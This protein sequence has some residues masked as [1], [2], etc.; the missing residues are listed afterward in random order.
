MAKNKKPGRPTPP[1]KLFDGL[2]SAFD[3]LEEHKP[4]EALA[5]LEDLD[6]A[7]PNSPDVLELLTNA[8]YDLNNSSRYEYAIRKLARIDPGEPSFIYGLAGAYLSNQ[9]P[10]LALRTFKEALRRWPN[11]EGA[12]KAREALPRIEEIMREQAAHLPSLNEKQ[13]LD[14]MVQHDELRCCLAHSEYYQ[15]RQ[16][17]EKLLKRYPDFVPA[18]NNL[19]QIHAVEGKVDLAIQT[20]LKVL[21][22]EPENIH[23][24]SNLTRLYFLSGRTAEASQYAA[25]L[26][27]S[28]AEAADRWTKIAEALTFLEDDAGVLALYDRAKAAGEQNPPHTDELFYHLLAVAAYFQGEEKDA[29]K[30]WK[31]SLEINPHFPWAVQ[32]LEDLKKPAKERGGAWAFPSEN[33]LLTPVIQE[34][35]SNVEKQARRAKKSDPQTYLV[36]YFEKKHPELLFLAPHLLA[37]GDAKGRDFAVRAA[38]MTALPDLVAA[39]KA[40]VFGK[41]GSFNE[42][43]QAAQILTEAGMIPSSS[44]QM[45]TGEKM[46]DVILMNIEISPEP[47]PSNMPR[48]AHDLATQAFEALYAGDGKRAQVLLEQ[49]L[50]ISPDSPSLMNN[51]A[52]AFDMQGQS[53]KARQIQQETLARFPDYF[54][55]IIAAANLEATQGSL[56][57]AHEMLNSLMQ[58]PKMHTSEF[59]ALCQAQI[60]ICLLEDQIDGAQSWLQMWEQVDSDNPS[61]EN[62]RAKIIQHR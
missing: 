5:I 36:E 49:A 27:D 59:T 55:G 1:R 51:L 58:R 13:A 46:T 16:V 14:L 24:L 2:N 42:R 22:H 26:K 54:F 34:L 31:K 12:A 11:H 20:S 60:Q 21:E 56:D 33:W 19:S 39:A 38:A 8:C 23:A 61:L 48:R 52:M 4:A 43:F 40:Y 47:E 62:F 32:N 28:K 57:R 35:I 41:R 7:Y 18:L 6:R 17:A 15:G 29:M 30:H 53:A 45:W 3:L 25:L 44:I 50:E 37:R 9:R 10:A